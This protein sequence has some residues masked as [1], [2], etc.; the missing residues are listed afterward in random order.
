MAFKT[1]QIQI[2]GVSQDNVLDYLVYGCEHAAKLANCVTYSVR[3]AHFESCPRT[4]YWDR[5]GAFRSGFKMKSVSVS[6]A[7]LCT[8][9]KGNPHYKALGGQQAQ[10]VIKSV[11]ESFRSYNKLIPLWFEGELKA[12]PQMPGY[13]SKGALAPFSIPNQGIA[14]NVEEGSV[15]I[16]V[17]LECK[18]DFKEIGDILILPSGFGF[19]P[20]QVSEVRILP[21]NGVLYAEYVY[22]DGSP[23]WPSCNLGLDHSKALGVDPGLDNWLTCVS[24]EGRSFIA[25]GRKVKSMNQLYNKRIAIIKEGR[26]QGYWD[27]QLA[28]LTETRNR[29]MRDAVNKTARLV[30]NDCL[31]HGY[32]SLVFGW[33]QGIK[34]NINLGSKTNQ[35]FVQIP[36][37]K[38][39]G[40]I[41]QLCVEYGIEFIE[42]EESYT[43]KTS[44][45][46]QDFLPTLGEKPK[47]WKPS[48]VRG[49][50]VKGKKNNLGRGGYKTAQGIR[51]NSDCN[52]AANILRKVAKQLDLN[53]AKIGRGALTLPQRFDIFKS[54]KRSYREEAVARLQTA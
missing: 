3:Q 13:R 54:M 5:Y 18:S 8:E 32:G 20:S 33:G 27:D 53:L 19:K 39:K 21:R 9:F 48:G 22:Q 38:L 12:R 34:D 45:L 25:D 46:D 30:I 47:S 36:T 2:T 11:V 44:F 7:A 50:R 26:P 1:Q 37:A 29:Q 24:T 31:Q 10:Q 4:E 43:S 52:G 42:T 15:R 6:Y 41:E 51:I 17:S 28:C 40:R 14:V 23:S 49:Q 35:E 16:P